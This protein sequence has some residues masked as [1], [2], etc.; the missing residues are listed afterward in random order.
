MKVV[1]ILPLMENDEYLPFV[2]DSLINDVDYLLF[3]VNERSWGDSE[4]KLTE[5]NRAWITEFV[6]TNPKFRLMLGEWDQEHKQHN[7][8]LDYAR[9]LGCDTVFCAATD[10]VYGPGTVKRILKELEA[11]DVSTVTAQW[12]IF[13]KTNPLCII[14]PT[15]GDVPTFAFKLKD[16]TYDGISSG[17]SRTGRKVQLSL[18][19]V[20]IFHFAYARSDE[21][22]KKKIKMSSHA[23][24]VAGDWF[25]RVWLN[26]KPGDQNLSPFFPGNLQR[27][28]EY[29][30]DK[31]PPKL[32][33]FFEKKK[34]NG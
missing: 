22:I 31:L 34:T 1:C 32:K 11:S 18:Q 27:A 10:Q 9:A 15:D 16:Y 23:H 14:Q 17:S 29:P 28:E 19:D 5:E 8:S 4:I 3:S 30:L 21:F 13:W 6:K 2:I 20:D 25:E 33:E 12:N 24:C 26:Y 7:A